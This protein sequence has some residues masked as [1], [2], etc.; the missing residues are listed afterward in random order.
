MS[1]VAAL[2]SEA[3]KLRRP[4]L[5]AG[6]LGSC[7][8]A[9]AIPALL[10]PLVASGSAAAPPGADA[11]D[12]AELEAAGG[13]A[14]ALVAG[15]S[16]LGLA[17]IVV[18][19]WLLSSEWAHGTWRGLLVRLPRP[20]TLLA[21]KVVG[22]AAL[23]VAGVAVGALVA[24]G[25]APVGAAAAGVDAS[26]W[27]SAQGLAD[28]AAATARL[29]LVSLGYGAIGAVL[30]IAFRAPV[31][32]IGV[33]VAYGLVLDGLVATVL[34]DAA[35]WL[36]G[37]ALAAVAA[38]GTSALGLG[39]ACALAVAWTTAAAVASGLILRRR[40]LGA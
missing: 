15:R 7:A 30:A 26:A 37:Q 1:L 28:A 27:W 38:G 33:G 34:G 8:A 12:V 10:T 9:L 24:T 18:V 23:L 31:P 29:A 40:G 6:V 13:L 39:A 22:A 21:A 3:V 36:P 25:A 4:A 20:G 5:I 19:A 11:I 2:R 17:A 32:A 35:A 16:L 14:D